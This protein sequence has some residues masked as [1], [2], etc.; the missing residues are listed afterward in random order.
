MRSHYARAY[1]LTLVTC[2]AV[3]AFAMWHVAS[4]A[5]DASSATTQSG[6]TKIIP[7][8]R[9]VVV[10][11]KAGVSHVWVDGTATNVIGGLTELWKT[12]PG[13]ADQRSLIDSGALSKSLNP[14]PNGTVFRF[15]QIPPE[16]R[17][18]GLSLAQKRKLWAGL[19]TKMHAPDAQ[20]DTRRDPGMHTTPTVDYIILLSGQITMVLEKGEVNMRPFDVGIKRGVNH[21]WVNRG[22]QEALLMAVLV[23]DGHHK[24]SERD[25]PDAAGVRV[26]YALSPKKTTTVRRNE[27]ELCTPIH[28]TR[29]RTNA[30]DMVPTVLIERCDRVANLT[31]GNRMKTQLREGR[32]RTAA[33][34]PDSNG[35][36]ERV[37]MLKGR[38]AVVTGSTSVSG[39]VS[40]ERWRVPARTCS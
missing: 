12:G 21:S 33:D 34:E 36:L 9:I 38:L 6:K 29:T 25:N 11:D 35:N 5:T 20:P 15:F 22:T 18:A 8:R 13:P 30:V 26:I 32:E 4:A 10:D 31:A 2:I 3:T 1:G 16:S 17:S 40:R 39:S 23:D 19:F 14:P 37:Q 27:H 28:S 7:V 24:Y